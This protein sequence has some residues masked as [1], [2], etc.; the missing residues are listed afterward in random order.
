MYPQWPYFKQEAL[1]IMM[2]RITW[3][4]LDV[5]APCLFLGWNFPATYSLGPPVPP[6]W[7]AC[8]RP[9][10]SCTVLW[11]IS[12]GIFWKV[13]FLLQNSTTYMSDIVIFKWQENL[14]SQIAIN[15]WANVEDVGNT[16][17]LA[18]WHWPNIAWSNT[19]VST[20]EV[21][22]LAQRWRTTH[23]FFFYENFVILFYKNNSSY[24]WLF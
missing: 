6:H 18:C 24:S 11:S 10:P 4:Y 15:R 20:V 5:K 1:C 12:I 21:L 2:R 3:M 8:H 9:N 13:L 17:L 14:Q 23:Y 22:L 16:S 19:R 7:Y